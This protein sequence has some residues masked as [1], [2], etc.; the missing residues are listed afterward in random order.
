ML[1]EQEVTMVEVEDSTTSSKASLTSLTGMGSKLG[2]VLQTEGG[3]FLA[4]EDL[5]TGRSD[6]HH[7]LVGHVSPPCFR[8]VQQPPRCIL[9]TVQFFL[10][11]NQYYGICYTCV[12]LYMC[13]VVLLIQFEC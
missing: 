1:L 4:T 9:E 10:L 12:D 3:L 2:L 6:G 5:E 13:Q 11:Q 7:H 8:I